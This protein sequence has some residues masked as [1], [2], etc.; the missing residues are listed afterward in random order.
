[1]A[2]KTIKELSLEYIDTVNHT[3]S[4]NTSRT[5]QNAMN[6]FSDVLK[7]RWIDPEKMD[8]SALA[9]DAIGWFAAYLKNYSPA[10]E[11]LYLQA[12]KGFYEYLASENATNINL[13]RIKLLI[14]QR[15]RRSG[16][17]L[18]QF[19]RNEIETII[20]Y[21]QEIADFSY[22]DDL[23]RLRAM[24]NR[25]FIISLADTGLRVSEACNL[26]RG[27]IDW[28][29]EKAIIIGKGDKEAVIRFSNRS[30]SALKEYLNTRMVFDGKAG[31]PLQA[32]PIFA[33]HDK[34]A[35]KKIKPISTTTGRKI[36]NDMSK[37]A[38]GPG[39]ERT[40]TPHSFRHY[41]VTTIL[42]AT[43][44]LKI[45]Q[46]LAR[47]TNISVTQRYAHISDNELD[48]KYLEIFDDKEN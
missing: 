35:G 21:V 42:N 18:P 41:F 16:I 48:E 43:G 34:G 9:E 46:E 15:S 1:V 5:Y 13:P 37:L 47:H 14:K 29:E 11:R 19:P 39:A 2:D 28:F 30:I 22:D 23:E 40:I 32:L 7:E 20:D 24:R 27:D 25:A 33:R 36:V 38:L 17:R 8:I 12:V 26:R 45:A 3:R 10:T 44:N 6:I 4:L 31:I